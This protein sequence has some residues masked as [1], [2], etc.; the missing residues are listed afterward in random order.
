MRCGSDSR[1]HTTRGSGVL[2]VLK[3]VTL[4]QK[5]ELHTVEAQSHPNSDAG[6]T[7][8]ISTNIEVYGRIESLLNMGEFFI[9]VY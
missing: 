5:N 8:A 3:P 9:L 1:F 7:P 6:S 2:F 4:N